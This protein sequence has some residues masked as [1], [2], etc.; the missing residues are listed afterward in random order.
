MM[1]LSLALLCLAL[2]PGPARAA[3]RPSDLGLG[4]VYSRV[5]HLPGDLPADPSVRGHPCVLDVRYV[6]GEGPAAAALAGWIRAHAGPRTPVILLAN[7]GT[8]PVL[9]AGLGP[10][11]SNPGLIVLGAAA[12]GFQ[13]DIAVAVD[14]QT[15]RRAYDALDAGA[16]LASLL[17]DNPEKPRNDEARLAREHLSD[18]ALADDDESGAEAAPKPPALPLP[19]IDPVLLRAVQLHRALLA[20]GKL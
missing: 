8:S 10:L 18:S 12:P 14:R 20:L 7:A 16:S 1:K 3:P 15:E 2:A 13:P 17:N 4:L 6:A 19:L 5:H 11:D 9:L